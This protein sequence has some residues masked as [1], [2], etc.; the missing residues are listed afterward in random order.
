MT[1]RNCSSNFRLIFVITGFLLFCTGLSSAFGSLLPENRVYNPEI[2]VDSCH[3]VADQE[4]QI[5]CCQSR[6]CHQSVPQKRDLDS[7][8][9]H[10]QHKVSHSL[11]H[12]SRPLLPK[13]K[14]GKPF[15]INHPPLSQ[16]FSRTRNSLVPLQSLHS[17]RTIV[18][19]N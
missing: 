9:Y 12:E 2:R 7:P 16:I 4:K 10:S 13:L 11:V 15:I 6:S 19:L 18:L 8:E 14:S 17:L 3:L 5:A 1:E